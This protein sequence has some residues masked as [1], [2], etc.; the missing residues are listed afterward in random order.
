[1]RVLLENEASTS[2]IQPSLLDDEYAENSV[3]ASA[4]ASYQNAANLH[5]TPVPSAYQTP[6]HTGAQLRREQT[7]PSY[8]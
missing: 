8:I 6:G 4:T 2:K 7:G 1:M 3:A 5:Q